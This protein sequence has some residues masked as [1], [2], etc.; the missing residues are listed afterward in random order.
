[1]QNLIIIRGNSGSGKSTV[2]EKLRG[3]LGG[4]VA[5]IG[6]DALRRTILGES[7]SLENTDI[8]ALL[9]QT[10]HYCLEKGY[11]VILEGILSKP[12]YGDV[13]LRLMDTIP[14]NTHVFYIDVSFEES[15]QRHI[16]KPIANEV[17]EEKLR[18]W[19]QPRNYL[20]VTGE[21]I[22]KENSTLEET[23]QLIKNSVLF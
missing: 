20:G 17:S 8:I 15:L 13:L 4:K 1:M 3:V 6:Q 10:T 11:S 22:I 19:Y 21:V 18:S 5:L 12:K 23:V 16:T 2:A 9:E 14:C 7:D